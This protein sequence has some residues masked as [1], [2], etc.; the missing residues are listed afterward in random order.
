M[1]TL[2]KDA[3]FG[4]PQCDHYDTINGYV[5]GAGLAHFL[6]RAHHPGVNPEPNNRFHIVENGGEKL[7]L[8]LPGNVYDY[9][10]CPPTLLVDAKGQRHIIAW[11]VR[12]EQPSIRDYVLGSE[13]EPAIVR[14]SKEVTGKVIGFQAF[15]GPAGRMVVLMEMNDTGKNTDDEL[16]VSMSDG[17]KWSAP[18]NVTNNT[19]KFHFISTNTSIASHVATLSYWYPGPAAATFD[20]QGHLLLAYISNKY[21]IVESNALGLTVAGGSSATPNLLFLRF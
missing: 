10:K 8:E 12:G 20:K 7:A 11:Y 14:A 1:A 19:G 6:A 9:W 5:D 15:Q 13:A 3:T 17:G 4:T 18:V 2:S 21:S 16:Y